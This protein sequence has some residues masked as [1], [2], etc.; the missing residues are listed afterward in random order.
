M[1]Q[2]SRGT[3]ELCA[4]CLCSDATG[5]TWDTPELISASVTAGS[6]S[7]V[8]LGEVQ[9]DRNLWEGWHWQHPSDSDIPV[10]IPAS[11]R[12]LSSSRCS[13]LGS[14]SLC[15]SLGVSPLLQ[16]R[17]SEGW[18]APEVLL[19][20]SS[21]HAGAFLQPRTG[22]WE[23]APGSV[24]CPT[25]PRGALARVGCVPW[26]SSGLC[27]SLTALSFLLTPRSRGGCWSW[28]LQ[29]R[30]GTSSAAPRR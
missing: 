11:S 17:G 3:G 12:L 25:C 8:P 15:C 29:A 18:E 6:L 27:L 23:V 1:V 28:G 10:P 14:L 21:S 4:G 26:C 5:V 19:G 2:S 13:V 9:R 30:R 24:P 7:S 22:P 16:S 20:H